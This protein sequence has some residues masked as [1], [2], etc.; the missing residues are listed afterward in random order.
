VSSTWP[1]PSGNSDSTSA[2]SSTSSK[3]S[4]HRRLGWPARK[5][6]RSRSTAESV[7]GARFSRSA[8]SCSP[9]RADSPVSDEIHQT[10]S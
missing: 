10:M 2:G 5:V 4:S 1:E 7:P 3:T 6:E 8:R 9:A